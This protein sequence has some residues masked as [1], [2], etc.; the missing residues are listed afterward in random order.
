MSRLLPITSKDK[1]SYIYSYNLD[2][3]SWAAPK[4]NAIVD[5]VKAQVSAGTPIDGIGSQ[6]HLEVSVI[7]KRAHIAVL[8]KFLGWRVDYGPCCINSTCNRRG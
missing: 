5:L 6:S 4:V 1:R 2:N 8:M 7:V 3:M